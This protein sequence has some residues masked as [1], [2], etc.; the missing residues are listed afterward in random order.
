M[1]R[2]NAPGERWEKRHELIGKIARESKNLGKELGIGVVLA[3]QLNRSTEK[4]GREP[5]LSDFRECGDLE[6]EADIASFLHCYKPKN[7]SHSVWWLIKKNRNGPLGT[8]HLR[9]VGDEVTFYDWF[10]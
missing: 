3:A 10:D 4:E 7:E 6:Q 5:Q 9:F 1:Q 2:I 8:I